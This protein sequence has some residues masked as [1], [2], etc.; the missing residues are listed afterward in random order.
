[1]KGVGVPPSTAL[2]ASATIMKLAGL[3]TT[4]GL[5]RSSLRT[6]TPGTSVR[7]RVQLHVLSFETATLPVSLSV[8]LTD[9]QF[10]IRT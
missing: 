5:V 3:P 10:W 7:I 1:M 6:W 4:T 2:R 9:A 8:T